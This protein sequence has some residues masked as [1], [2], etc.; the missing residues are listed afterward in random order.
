MMMSNNMNRLVTIWSD[1]TKANNLPSM[2]ASELLYYENN[3]G[4]YITEEQ[5]R[6]IK[7]FIEIWESMSAYTSSW[8]Q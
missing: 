2:S 6:F 5:D 4:E 7:A 3:N 1:W 8:D